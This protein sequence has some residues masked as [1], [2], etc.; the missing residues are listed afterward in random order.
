MTEPIKEA[1]E[2]WGRAVGA[3]EM[4]KFRMSDIPDIAAALVIQE[5]LA[6]RD[7]LRPMSEAPRDR[8]PVLVKLRDDAFRCDGGRFSHYAG[9]WFVAYHE[10]TT[11]SDYDLGW[12]L[13]PGFGGVV[14]ANLE[15]W[16]PL[17]TLKGRTDD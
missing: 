15:G 11:V 6:E 2:I 12:G 5:A 16:L 7:G 4:A 3:H 14:D 8:T 17:P 10:G 9:R 13:F 1:M